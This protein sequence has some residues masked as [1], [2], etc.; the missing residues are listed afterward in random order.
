MEQQNALIQKHCAVCHTDAHPN[1]GLSLQ[2]FDVSHADP[3]VAAMVR[4]KVLDGAFRAAGIPGPTQAD[5]AAIA[6]A[7]DVA[8]K[9]ADQWQVNPNGASIVRAAAS[10]AHPSR[11]SLYRLT[12]GCNARTKNVE[13]QLDWA[14]DVPAN[15][16]QLVATVDTNLRAFVTVEGQEKMGNGNGATSGPG[17]I[18]L[19]LPTPRSALT[20]S[21][22][23]W[24][25]TVEFSFR[26]LPAKARQTLAGCR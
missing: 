21:D 15:G 23:F 1:G 7:L 26:D 20:I 19:V 6:E 10:K 5:E 4:S 17:S 18:K 14:P 12:V 24:N 16:Q 11:P 2:H 25:E 22:L 3:G 13:M 9:G 8:S